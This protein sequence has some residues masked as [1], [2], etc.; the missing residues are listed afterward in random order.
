MTGIVLKKQTIVV[1]LVI[2]GFYFILA[3][4]SLEGIKY[5]IPQSSFFSLALK[6]WCMPA[7]WHII[8]PGEIIVLN[9]TPCLVGWQ[10]EVIF[11]EQGKM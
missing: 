9:H 6:K 5:N 2:N 4:K 1:S 8:K 7:L 10:K 11:H 3:M